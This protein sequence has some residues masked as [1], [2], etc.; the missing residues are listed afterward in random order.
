MI[1]YINIMLDTMHYLRCI[2]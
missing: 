1:H 2:L